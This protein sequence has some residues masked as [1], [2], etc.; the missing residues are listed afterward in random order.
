MKEIL[1]YIIL[2]KRVCLLQQR[3]QSKEV[4]MSEM[5]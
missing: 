5:K 1:G 2:F 3:L 4:L